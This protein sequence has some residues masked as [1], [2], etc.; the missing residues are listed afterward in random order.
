MNKLIETALFMAENSICSQDTLYSSTF[1]KRCVGRVFNNINLV[2]HECVFNSFKHIN[3]I[4]ALDQV[5]STIQ[6]IASK[7]IP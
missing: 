6:L 2:C 7:Q 4:D 3:I 5:N 1:C